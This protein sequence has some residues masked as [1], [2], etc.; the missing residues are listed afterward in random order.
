[1]TPIKIILTVGKDIASLVGSRLSPK[2]RLGWVCGLC[3][4]IRPSMGFS[5]NHLNSMYPSMLA[6][7]G[8]SL[9]CLVRLGG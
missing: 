9:N 3:H 2:K 1:M 8:V 4:K 7:G 5:K 6:K